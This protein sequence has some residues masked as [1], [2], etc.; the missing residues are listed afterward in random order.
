MQRMRRKKGERRW[1]RR[2]EI[3]IGGVREGMGM[4]GRLVLEVLRCGFIWRG[5]G[6]S[7]VWDRGWE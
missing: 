5:G 4:I 3:G 7:E 6:G 1:G 2:R